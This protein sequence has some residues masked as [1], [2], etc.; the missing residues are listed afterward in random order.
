MESNAFVPAPTTTRQSLP[1]MSTTILD[2]KPLYHKSKIGQGIFM[3]KKILS[4]KSSQPLLNSAKKV[5]KNPRLAESG[6]K[7]LGHY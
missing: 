7:M 1:I 3:K 2:K 6:D 5:M 4:P